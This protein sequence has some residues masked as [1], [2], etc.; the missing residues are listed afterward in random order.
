MDQDARAPSLV[1]ENALWER[2]I[3]R[4]VGVD[5]AGLGSLCGPV[6]AAAVLVPVRCQIIKGVRD[7][8]LLSPCQRETLFV[9]IIR[10]AIAVGVGA[11]SVA[12]IERLNVRVA[13]HLAMKRALDR[14]GPYDYALIDGNPMT[15]IDLGPHAT[16]VD[17]DTFSYAIACAS[18]VAKVTRDRLMTKLARRFPGYGWDHNAGYGTAEHLR[19]L[20][21]LGP[22]PYH[23]LDYKPVRRILG[24]PPASGTG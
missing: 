22:T 8:K 18:V 10:Q 14:I 20:N 24:S 16:I 19:A 21:S 17:G 12:E 9:E 3:W 2:A 23:R 5:E 11:A 7:S 1:Y 6:V 15:G 13:S 4:V